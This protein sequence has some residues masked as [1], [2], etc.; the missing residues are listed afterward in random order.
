VSNRRFED[1]RALVTAAPAR[2]DRFP[3]LPYAAAALRVDEGDTVRAVPL[4]PG[5]R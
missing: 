1:F 3:L 2:A 5:D 4:A